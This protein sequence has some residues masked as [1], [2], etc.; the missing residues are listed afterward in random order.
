MDIRSLF[1]GKPEEGFFVKTTAPP[2]IPSSQRAAL[3]RKGNAL[4]NEGNIELAKRIF[5]T[6]RYGD[7]LIRVGDYH[8]KRNEFLEAFRMYWLAN[9][10]VKSEKLIEKM[11][12]V[13]REWIH[14]GG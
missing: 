5:I 3:V 9:E 12:Q 8:Y 7:G 4:F 11:A 13:I 14:A 2:P 6:L 10:K 1:E